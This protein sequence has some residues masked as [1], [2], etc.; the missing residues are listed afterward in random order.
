MNASGLCS[1][2]SVLGLAM[3]CVKALLGGYS[4]VNASRGLGVLPF[5]SRVLGRAPAAGHM[6]AVHGLALN[7]VGRGAAGG[8]VWMLGRYGGSVPVVGAGRWAGFPN[9]ADLGRRCMAVPVACLA[10]FA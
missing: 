4:R 10:R 2:L 7:A 5:V 6:H 9:P 1:G 8:V 3:C